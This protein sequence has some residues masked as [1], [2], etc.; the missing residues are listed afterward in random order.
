MK[1]FNLS[2]DVDHTFEGWFSSAA[3]FGRQLEA[4]LLRCPVCDSTEVRRL[5]AATRLNL[6]APAELA[7]RSQPAAALADVIDV[8]IANSEDVGEQ[9]AEEARRIHYLE[10]KARSIRGIATVEERA[11]LAEEGIDVLTLPIATA[12]KRTLQ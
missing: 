7:A 12:S 1:V 5:P 2:C 11:Q 4:H 10:T 9:F 6:G 8:L 3:E